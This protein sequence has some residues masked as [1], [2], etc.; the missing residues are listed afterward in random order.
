MP[1]GPSA[2]PGEWNVGAL[3]KHFESLLHEHEKQ[4]RQMFNDLQAQID[5]RLQVELNE[6]EYMERHLTAQIESGDLRLETHIEAQ[7]EAV[8]KA[9]QNIDKRLDMLNQLR[10]A[11]EEDR[12]IFIGRKEAET[13]YEALSEQIVRSEGSM[14]EVFLAASAKTDQRLESFAERIDRVESHID[15]RQGGETSERRRQVQ[16][17]PWQ[18]WVAGA[19]LSLVIVIVNILIALGGPPL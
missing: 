10:E 11:V 1:N 2:P 12:Q 8:N 5:R 18:I 9:E 15:Q 19:I 14:R 4:R 13:K 7:R 6:R 3:Y 17:Q 16:T